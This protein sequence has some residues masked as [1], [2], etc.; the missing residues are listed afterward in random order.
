[1]RSITI[2]G[3]GLAGLSLGIGLRRVGVPVVVREAGQYPRHRVCG[4]FI[5]GLKDSTI[6]RL[7]LE[8]CL[9]ESVALDCT[10]WYDSHRCLRADR[11]PVVARGLSRWTLDKNLVGELTRLGGRLETGV[12][13]DRLDVGAGLVD[14]AGRQPAKDRRWIG[15]KCHVEGFQLESD[16]EMHMSAAGYVGLSRI[17]DG[18]VNLCGLFR[19][20]GLKPG[21]DQPFVYDYLESCGFGRLLERLQRACPVEGSACSVAALGYG[22]P[23][24]RPDALAL[25][26][27]RGLIPPFTG[28]G[29]TLAFESAALAVAPLRAYAQGEQ[30]WSE[31]SRDF[32]SVARVRFGRRLAIARWIHRCLVSARWFPLTALAARSPL[33]PFQTLFRLTR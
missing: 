16:L 13:C 24:S 2:I 33:F 3:G 7:G 15:L 17:E 6:D 31:C 30:S 8:N 27:A 11:L 21:G 25:G 28:N 26:D 19:Q 23:R 4:E 12:R 9:R 18:R 1:M 29:M 20:E 14:C 10:R 32:A 5:S 22:P